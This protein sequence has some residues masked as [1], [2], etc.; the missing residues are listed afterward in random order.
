MANTVKP[1]AE[2]MHGAADIAVKSLPEQDRKIFLEV[3]YSKSL[4]ETMYRFQ[5]DSKC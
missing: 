3:M 5:L 2:L 1:P 4:E